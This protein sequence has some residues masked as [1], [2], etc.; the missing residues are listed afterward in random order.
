MRRLELL[1]PIFDGVICLFDAIGH[2]LT[3][4]AVK[5][6]FTGVWHHLRPEG[7]FILEFWHAAAIVSRHDAVR[8]RRLRTE[9]GEIIRISETTLDLAQQSASVQHSIYE[10]RADGT[11]A[12]AVEQ[13][14]NR[15]FSL[16]EMRSLLHAS[17]FEVVKYYSGYSREEPLTADTWHIVVIAR[18]SEA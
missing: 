15:F 16:P 8:V 3:S 5:E 4:V 13:Q 17:R 12:F 2:V 6:T 18:R 11:Y 10:H 7:L 9:Q 1:F 14:T